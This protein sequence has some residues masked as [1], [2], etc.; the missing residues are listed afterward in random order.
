MPRTTVKG[1]KLFDL[2][3]P[4]DEQMRR[5]PQSVKVTK[6]RMFATIEFT[7]KQSRGC[8][9]TELTFR[10]RHAMHDNDVALKN[11][12]GFLVCAAKPVA[13]LTGPPPSIDQAM[14]RIDIHVMIPV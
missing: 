11:V 5:N 2:A 3:C 8:A 13:M 12:E 7:G 1:N 9:G 10:Q 4:I 6:T 14:C